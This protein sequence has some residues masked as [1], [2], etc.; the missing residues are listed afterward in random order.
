MY[1][2]RCGNQRVAFRATVW[3]MK[4]GSR[5]KEPIQVNV[6]LT[7]ETGRS[8]ARLKDPDP[9]LSRRSIRQIPH[10][11]EVAECSTFTT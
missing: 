9:T 2:S 4:P 10:P 6:S 1:Q 7:R 11:I 5:P 8:S 3:H